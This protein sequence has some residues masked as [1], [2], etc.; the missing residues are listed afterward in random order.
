M[1]EELSFRSITAP[2]KQDKLS[3]GWFGF[4]WDVPMSLMGG[5]SLLTAWCCKETEPA[6]YLGISVQ[7]GLADTGAN[8]QK[9]VKLGFQ[10][11]QLRYHGKGEEKKSFVLCLHQYSLNV[12]GFS[13]PPGCSD[14]FLF[15]DGKKLG[16]YGA[17]INEKAVEE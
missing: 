14:L 9:F 17:Y 1:P 10:S 13:F 16:W 5:L 15:S 4:V 7:D 11:V 8:I 2:V 12:L 3:P 6:F